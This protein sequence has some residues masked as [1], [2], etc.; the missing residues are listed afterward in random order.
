MASA[1]RWSAGWVPS[2]NACSARSIPIISSCNR[3]GAKSEGKGAEEKGRRETL[4]LFT[5]QRGSGYV[6]RDTQPLKTD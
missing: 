3:C 5:K 4:E 1:S 2:R 6:S